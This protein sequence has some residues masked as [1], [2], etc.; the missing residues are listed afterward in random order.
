MFRHLFISIIF[1]A[2]IGAST[3]LY[4]FGLERIQIFHQTET[5]YPLALILVFGFIYLVKRQ[6]LYFPTQVDQVSASTE[7]EQRHWSP[8]SYLWNILGSW[9]SHLAGASLGR[10]GSVLVLSSSLAQLCRLNWAYYRAIVISAAFACVIGQPFIAAIFIMEMFATNIDQKI[11]SVVMAWVGFLVMQSLDVQPIF[12]LIQADLSA[13]FFDK[14]F[15]VI[16]IGIVV[17]LVTNV[18][19]FGYRYL[20][21]VFKKYNI[22]AILVVLTLSWIFIQP[23]MKS[24][25]SLSLNTF[26]EIQNGQADIQFVFLKTVF[27]L[28]FI[29]L[30]FIGGDFVPAISIGAGTGVLVANVFQVSFTFG[31]AMGL[32]AFFTGLTRLKW[33]SLWILFFLG[34]FKVMLWGYVCLSIT[35]QLSGPDSLYKKEVA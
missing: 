16:S 23:E 8:F 30:G 7:L 22:A 34:G 21:D 3:A 10:E 6:T 4:S 29:S 20:S 13:G 9:L 12:N 17:G 19:K 25:H 27:T 14:L 35:R 32:M 15:V 28:L 18:F 26:S 2:L 5:M 31:L 1:G 11:F 24:L 33:T